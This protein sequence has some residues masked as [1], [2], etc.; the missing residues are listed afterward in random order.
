MSSY[1][2]VKQVRVLVFVD[3]TVRP[4]ARIV[5]GVSSSASNLYAL[6]VDDYHMR[7]DQG[8]TYP[9]IGAAHQAGWWMECEYEITS[10]PLIDRVL[11]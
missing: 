5:L 7:L 10:V 8:H 2:I 4:E 9:N 11:S 6:A 3:K 1:R